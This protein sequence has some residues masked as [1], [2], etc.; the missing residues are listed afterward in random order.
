M[1]ETDRRLKDKLN[2]NQPLRERMCLELLATE[3]HFSD[4]RPR[5][6]NGG[7]DGGRD[8]E[9]RYKEDELVFGAIGFVNNATDTQEHRKAAKKKFHEDLERAMAPN[10]D[11]SIHVPRVFV[12]FTNVGLTPSI[13]DELQK[14]AYERGVVT[15]EIYD[16]ERIRILLDRATGYG[17]RIRYLD[18]PLSD[19]EQKEFFTDWGEQVQQLMVDTLPAINSTTRRLNFLAEAQLYAETITTLVELDCDLIDATGTS[20]LFETMIS[21]RVHSAGLM[22]FTFGK[23]SDACATQ[24]QREA[25]DGP[26]APDTH[27][28]FGFFQFI[29]GFERYQTQSS[30][31]DET[32]S[33]EKDDFS[34]RWIEAGMSHGAIDLYRPYLQS[35]YSSHPLVL[36]GAPTCRLIELDRAMVAFACNSTLAKQIKSIRVYA[37]NYCILNIERDDL[38]FYPT[39]FDTF[40]LSEN[41][42]I[43]EDADTWVK[44]RPASGVTCFTPDFIKSTP[45]RIH[46]IAG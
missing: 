28:G 18:I 34:P 1:S 44:I 26:I 17:I 16:R 9:A 20:F 23:A 24:T 22:G 35:S 37:N 6:P 46:P 33:S 36:R 25:P 43:T 12:F 3:K 14:A 42:L 41:V 8:I 27:L 40:R 10:L 32:L 30:L 45:P 13:R 29:P 39:K 7:P 15:C 2:A 5:L 38:R 21:L 31:F 11:E 19:A 4:V